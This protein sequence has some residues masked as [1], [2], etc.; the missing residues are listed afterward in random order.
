[1]FL[2]RLFYR[3]PTDGCSSKLFIV[4]IRYLCLLLVSWGI[5]FFEGY[6]CFINDDYVFFLLSTPW[7]C[8]LSMNIFWCCRFYL[9][10]CIFFVFSPVFS[11][12]AFSVIFL[13]TNFE[14]LQFDFEFLHRDSNS[15]CPPSSI[16]QTA[17][18]NQNWGNIR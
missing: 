4:T 6:Y 18:L 8:Q 12:V 7:R 13:K 2:K 15:A 3:T 16:F 1:M 11:T 17:L 14:I 5:L 9:S 10:L